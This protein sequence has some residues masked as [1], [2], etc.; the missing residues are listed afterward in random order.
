MTFKELLADFIA[1]TPIKRIVWRGYWV[2]RFGKIEMHTKNG[3]VVNFLDTEDVLFTLSGI[4]QDDWE[5]ANDKNCDIPVPNGRDNQV[6]FE[7]KFPDIQASKP[8][9]P[10]K[11]YDY[12]NKGTSLPIDLNKCFFDSN[13]A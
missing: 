4:L 9:Y 2:Y 5:Y 1:G 6:K 11:P 3:D 13:Q 12:W 10:Y 7:W 8:V